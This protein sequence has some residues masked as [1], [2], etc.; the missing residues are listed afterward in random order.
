MLTLFHHPDCPHSR[1]VRLALREYG[2]PVRQI[3]ERIW[4]RRKE[5]LILNPAGTTPVLLTEEQLAVPGASIIA[6]YLEETYGRNVA[7][8]RLLPLEMPGRIEVRRLMHWFNDEFFKEVTGPLMTER[9]KQYKPLD[10]DGGPPDYALIRAVFQNIPY[11]LAHI[12]LLLRGHDWLAGGRLSYADLA[13]AAHLSLADDL[14]E[15]PWPEDGA[16]KGW[17]ERMRSRLT[18]QSVMA[19]AWRGVVT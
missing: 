3:I 7:E 6:E 8:R 14:G 19:Q 11:Y 9:Y 18:F 4:E 12:G 15:I 2:L 5:F 1:F 10:G 16:A 13:A 17:Y